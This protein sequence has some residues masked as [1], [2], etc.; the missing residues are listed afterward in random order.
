[1]I[2]AYDKHGILT[3]HKVESGKTI[4]GIYYEE[5]IKKTL[6]QA[7]RR[8]RPEPFATGPIILHDNETPHDANGVTSLLGQYEWE[9]V[10][11]PPYSPDISPCDFDLF[12]KLQEYMRGIC[13]NDLKELESAVAARVRVLENGCLAT[14]IDDQPKRW[15]SVID[16]KRYYFEGMYNGHSS[17]RF[18][19]EII[20]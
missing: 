5:Y 8:K 20:K 14:G 7:I 17:K 2:F 12:P 18:I 6:R 19:T 9:T 15:E 4:N 3:S 16:H 10:D 13:Y 11:H 1:M